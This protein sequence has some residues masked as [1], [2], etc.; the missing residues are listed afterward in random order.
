VRVLIQEFPI[1]LGPVTLDAYLQQP[2]E[3]SAH[4]MLSR[5]STNCRSSLLKK[6]LHMIT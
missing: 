5:C 1:A 6:K 3:L 4:R 2:P